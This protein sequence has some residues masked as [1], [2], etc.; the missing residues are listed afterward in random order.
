VVVIQTLAALVSRYWWVIALRGAVAI[1]FGVLAFA[2]P[3]ATLATLVLL[4]GAYAIVDGVAAVVVGVKEYGEQER[5]WATLLGG[6]VSIGAGVITFMMPG[7]T[8]LTLLTLIALW[9]ILRGALE[10]MAAVRLRHVIQ[11]EWLLGLGGV[12]S[13]LFGVAMIAY[14]GAGALAVIWWIA[15]Y[16]IVLGLMLVALG[17]RARGLAH[18]AAG[19]IERD[20]LGRAIAGSPRRR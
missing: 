13:I 5:W 12:L 11:G 14:P 1:L 4:F 9:A 8:A 2:W 15:A 17:F 3:G 18:R 16:A 6:L 10:I 20:P 19:P 7:I